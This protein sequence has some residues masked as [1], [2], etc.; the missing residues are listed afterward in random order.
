[1]DA[2]DGAVD[3]ASEP[4]AELV[5]WALADH[6]DDNRRRSLLAMQNIAAERPLFAAIGERVINRFDDVT[7]LAQIVQGRIQF[8]DKAH[9]PGSISL[10]RL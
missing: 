2:P 7:G 4:L 10:A 5:G 1:M 6:P 3:N 9:M 8:S